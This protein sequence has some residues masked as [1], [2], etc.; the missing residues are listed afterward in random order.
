MTAESREDRIKEVIGNYINIISNQTVL[1]NNL[2]HELII[3]KKIITNTDILTTTIKEKH[4]IDVK[5]HKIKANKKFLIGAGV[6][7]GVALVVVGFLKY[8]FS[9]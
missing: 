2:E 3:N 1:I 7:S 5:L 9:R 6:G 8:I 4:K